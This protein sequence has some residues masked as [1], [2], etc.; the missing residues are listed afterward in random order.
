M[1]KMRSLIT[2]FPEQLKQAW[3]IAQSTPIDLN[4]WIPSNVLILGMGGSGISGSIASKMLADTSPVPIA[5]NNDYTVPA[6]TGDSTL[7]VACSYSG[8]TE[9]TLAALDAA[10]NAGARVVAITSGGQLGA[11]CDQHAWPSVRIPGGEPPRS[12]FGFA[13]TSVMHVLHAAGLVPEAVYG[14]FGSAAGHLTVNQA[15]CIERAE[16]LADL[17]EGKQVLL[18][19]DAAQE[20]LAIRWRQ[21]LNENAKLLCSHHVFP[22]MNHN[23]LVGWETG[24][25]S[26]VVLM[27]QTP[28]YHKRTR[29]RMEVCMEIFQQQGADVVVVEG[30]GEDAVLRFFDLVHVGDWL[31]LVLAERAGV[32]P[33]D[34]K[35]IDHLKNALAQI[36]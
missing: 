19:S 18:Y 15:N 9:E 26:H 36:P 13:F 16:A 25:E 6:W 8:N 32:D 22:E 2:A 27:I 28:E 10:V 12:Q 21:Q 31:S 4:G 1:E 7:V 24:D 34:I 23:E 29:I 35:N 20:G 30:D 11:L 14:A 33:V 5:A 3:E 17:V